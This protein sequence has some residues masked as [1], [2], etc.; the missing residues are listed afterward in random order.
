MKR[1][2]LLLFIIVAILMGATAVCAAPMQPK[3]V[4]IAAFN[5]YPTLFQAND[6]TIQ[7]FYVDFLKEIAKREGWDIE[8]VYGN[9]ADGLARIKSDEVD[10]LT[11]VAYTPE[12]DKEMDYGKTPLLTVWAELY[13]PNGSSIDNIRQVNGKKIAIMKG[14]F[15]AAN[16]RNLL[17]KFEIPCQLIE[18]SNFEEV[19]NAVSLRQVDGGVVNNTFGSAKQH[20]YDI[21]SSGIIFNPFDIFFTVAEGKNRDILDTL[22]RYLS[23][24][25]KTEGSPYHAARERWSHGSA[26][27]IKVI[28]SWVGSAVIIFLLSL[29]LATVFIVA[30]RIQVRRKTTELKAQ[31]EERKVIEDTLFLVNE[32][33]ASLRGAALLSDIT[34]HLAK[35][36]GADVAFVSKMLPGMESVRTIGLNILG[37]KAQEIEYDLR[38]TPCENVI[39]GKLCIYSDNIVEQFPG[40]KLLVK[41]GAVGYAATPLRNSEGNTIGLIGLITKAPLK[42]QTL[43]EAILNIAATRSAQELEAMNHLQALE[44]KNFTIENTSDAVYWITNDGQ[45]WDVNNSAVN[46][47]GYTRDELLAMLVADVDPKFSKETW[48]KQWLAVKTAKEIRIESLHKTKDG[49]EFPVEITITHFTFNDAEYHCAIARDITERKQAEAASKKMSLL[50]RNILDNL[51]MMAWLK[52][53]NG[54]YE[55][56]NQSFIDASGLQLDDIIGKTDLD[57]LPH[58]LAVRYRAD[59][60]EVMRTRSKKQVEEPG[61]DES[62]HYLTFKSPLSDHDENIV[63]TTGVAIDVTDLKIAEHEKINLQ[64]QLHQAQKM[65]SV[66]RLAGGVAHDFNNMLSVIIGHA[67]L[68]L[69]D[70]DPANPLHTHL[71]EINNAAERSAELTRQLLA[72]A[73]KQTIAPKVLNMN[74]T[75]AGML[76]ML[77]RLIGEDI[78][79]VWQSTPNLWQIK[80]DPSQL[81]QLLANLCVNARDAISG[82]GKITI[83]VTNCTITQEYCAVFFDVV[84][85][86]YVKLSVSD[87]GCGMDKETKAHI[88][89]P[90]FTT[91]G[92]GEGTGLGLATV[93]GIVKQNNGFINVYSEL[94]QGT[95]FTVYLPRKSGD[96]L[97]VEMDVAEP[98]QSGNETILLVE[99]EAAI[100]RMTTMMLEKQGYTVLAANSPNDAI[101]LSKVHS[102]GIHLLMTDVVMPEM[103]GRDLVKE[104]MSHNPN[105]KCLF[106]SGYTANVIAHHGV[107]DEGVNF[108]QK[109][110]SLPSMAAKVREVLES[111]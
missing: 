82:N 50:Q 75:L 23:E 59:D 70:I 87:D 92:A 26:S 74:E 71:V 35:A 99:D 109:P 42:K 4:R 102:R 38:G 81:D 16:F 27:T 88:F 9:W 106:M 86:D 60:H 62:R 57:I 64:A 45:F 32:S 98:V 6:G 53:T 101:R 8:Y 14:D 29:A 28:P 58:D 13:V 22:D 43:I 24:W 5:F 78:Q 11:N 76:K 49:N 89:E 67:S 103:N 79:L 69:M 19:F 37:S 7:G 2:S 110:F 10:V 100:L 91:K 65:E 107:L 39:N 108:I 90:F 41:M 95:T 17:D 77:Q 20:V 34:S 48:S 30:L 68:G 44:L 33:G 52:D 12:R 66:G 55:M 94:N 97:V 36:L 47:L 46:M 3:K 21:K 85:G 72:F 83:E 56:V 1:F 51:P 105:L 93:Y 54:K 104:L 40:D 111:N 84:P 63:G 96:E 18:Y 25:R 15:N 80:A 31:L 61:K 73:R